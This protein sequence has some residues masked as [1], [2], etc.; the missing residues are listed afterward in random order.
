MHHIFTDKQKHDMH[1]FGVIPLHIHEL[2]KTGDFTSFSGENLIDLGRA[3]N[4]WP[5]TYY[6][7]IGKELGKVIYE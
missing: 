7:A 5:S 3:Y 6:S 4:M 2:V 1:K